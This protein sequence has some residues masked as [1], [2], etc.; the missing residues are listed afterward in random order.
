MDE[1]V[2]KTCTVSIVRDGNRI[3]RETWKNDRGELDRDGAPAYVNDYSTGIRGTEDWWKDGRRHREGGP[4]HVF[5]HLHGNGFVQCE[6]WYQHGL[7][8]RDNEEPAYIHRSL[9]GRVKEIKYAFN[10]LLHR[11]TG[12][13]Y[14]RRSNNTGR[15]L[16]TQ[17][18][19]HGKRMPAPD[20]KSKPSPT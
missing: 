9:E 11:T 6:E 4:A 3:A 1:Y 5:R 10:G 7:L 13:A 15:V 18:W 14:I 12:P 19:R 17:Y 8:H 20:K 16:E 2:E